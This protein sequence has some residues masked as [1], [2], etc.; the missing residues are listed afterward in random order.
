M[1]GCAPWHTVAFTPRLVRT[2]SKF[3]SHSIVRQSNPMMMGSFVN[4]G[5]FEF[6]TVSHFFELPCL[7]LSLSSCFGCILGLCNSYREP[8]LGVHYIAML[9]S[10][11]FKNFLPCHLSLFWSHRGTLHLPLT[12]RLNFI[13]F[14]R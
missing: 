7:S 10:S 13:R 2:L 5:R 14:Q 6:F 3:F 8:K 12:L 4:G 1:I 9:R 11:E